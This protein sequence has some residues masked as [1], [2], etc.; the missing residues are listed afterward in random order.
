LK[1]HLAASNMKKL[2]ALFA[3]A[4]FTSAV[5][6]KEVDKHQVWPEPVF[7]IKETK[8]AYDSLAVSLDSLDQ[9]LTK[10]P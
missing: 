4:L 6:P 3:A 8:L 10:L 5:I 2:V 1:N 7:K 9:K